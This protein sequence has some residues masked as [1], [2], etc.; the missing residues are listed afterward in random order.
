MA[1]DSK[2]APA[3]ASSENQSGD[4]L[5]AFR[6]LFKITVPE[7][8]VMIFTAYFEDYITVPLRTQCPLF[9]ILQEESEKSEKNAIL[10][11]HALAGWNAI[12]DLTFVLDDDIA[13]VE[14]N[15]TTRQERFDIKHI[16]SIR[17]CV[18]KN[19]GRSFKS[20][21]S[22]LKSDSDNVQTKDLMLQTLVPSA[23]ANLKVV[24]ENC[25]C[26]GMSDFAWRDSGSA[27]V[28]DERLGAERIS[29]IVRSR[30]DSEAYRL[31]VTNEAPL[32]GQPLQ[33]KEVCTWTAPF[34]VSKEPAFKTMYMKFGSSEM[35]SLSTTG[36]VQRIKD[37]QCEPDTCLN[38]N[39]CHMVVI[40]RAL[41][42]IG[43]LLAELDK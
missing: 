18:K 24:V 43:I 34:N 31:A 7:I 17:L 32:S 29:Q 8:S 37:R 35:T 21:F 42:L 6:F 20:E 28:V 11:A 30:T 39:I 9:P 33:Y 26:S 5:K 41:S 3:S 36:Q 16:A 1:T 14:L 2:A 10:Y 38:L 4:C 15:R 13:A 40:V 27:T 22:L 12:E 19:S 23:L 25:S